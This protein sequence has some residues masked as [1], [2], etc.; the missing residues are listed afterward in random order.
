MA[1]FSAMAISNNAIL[2]WSPDGG[3]MAKALFELAI[4]APITHSSASTSSKPLSDWRAERSRLSSAW[5]RKTRNE[6]TDVSKLW[7]TQERYRR[8]RFDRVS[9]VQAQNSQHIFYR[10]TKQNED[11]FTKRHNKILRYLVKRSIICEMVLQKVY[12]TSIN[13]SLAI[14]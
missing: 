5:K 8:A 12:C 1:L 9:F 3:W 14:V 13:R 10:D 7:P 11:R 6:K 4:L 2:F